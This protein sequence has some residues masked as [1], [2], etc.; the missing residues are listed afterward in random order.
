MQWWKMKAQMKGVGTKI[1]FIKKIY[2]RY[3]G[4]TESAQYCFSTWIRLYRVLLS[5]QWCIKDKRIVEFGCGD[6]LGVGL[7]AVLGGAS[8]YCGL[9]VLPFA[10]DFDAEQMVE[11]IVSLY[12][13][14]SVPQRAIESIP[15]PI[16]ESLLFQRRTAADSKELS[17]CLEYRAPWTTDS[18]NESSV[19]MVFSNS[20]MEHVDNLT[21]A[22]GSMHRWLVPGG[23]SIH[24]IDFK[25]HG[26]SPYSNGHWAFSES[27]WSRV[28]GNRTYFLNR[29][30]LSRHFDI[31]E[32]F[33]FDILFLDI[34]QQPNPIDVELLAPPATS[35]THEDISA[36]S[37][38]V[39]LRKKGMAKSLFR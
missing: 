5:H 20:V 23:Y 19:D 31:L 38:T 22:Y 17:A 16:D 27:E 24:V 4:N 21:E 36:G 1:P 7:A 15:N 35:Y 11:A 3:S 14:G 30:P 29:E 39:L 26:I 37:A 8:R 25:S 28:V 10:N 13:Q 18:V 9:D 32:F 34:R 2:N 33:E 12:D 6:S